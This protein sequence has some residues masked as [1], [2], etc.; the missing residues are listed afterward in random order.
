MPKEVVRVESLYTIEQR[1]VN[2]E[3]MTRQRKKGLGLLGAINRGKVNKYMGEI[4]G[5]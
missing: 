1:V 2:C 3:E 5:R 4:N